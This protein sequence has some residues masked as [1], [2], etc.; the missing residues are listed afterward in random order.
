MDSFSIFSTFFGAIWYFFPILVIILIIKT[1]W[2]KGLFGE[3]IVYFSAWLSLDKKKYHIIRN[4]T[5]PAYDETTQIDLIIISIY[6]VFVIEVKN[7][8]GWIFGSQNQKTWTQKIFKHTNKFQNP[9]RQNY[10]HVKTLESLLGLKENQIHS[11]VVF[12]GDSTFK[13]SMPENV[14]YGWGYIRH[15]KSKKQKVLSEPDVAE[16]INKIENKRLVRSFKTNK[17]HI[18]NVRTIKKG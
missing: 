17:E 7:M 8:K 6:G 15:I 12:I 14:T 1:P 18:K 16:M 3:F 10:K 4:V 5:L 2:F 11:V 9:L 13:T